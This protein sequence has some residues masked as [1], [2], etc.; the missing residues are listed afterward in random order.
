[1]VSVKAMERHLE[2]ARQS[3]IRLQKPGDAE[4]WAARM[5]EPSREARREI[6]R[7]WGH[8]EFVRLQTLAF[9]GLI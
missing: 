6:D 8:P 2:E 9:H 1:M 4:K 5:A 7:A 3:V